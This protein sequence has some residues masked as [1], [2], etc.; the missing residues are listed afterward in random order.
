MPEAVSLG[1]VYTAAELDLKVFNKNW[2]SLIGKLG[3][4]GKQ[5]DRIVFSPKQLLAGTDAAEAGVVGLT[6]AVTGT[7]KQVEALNALKFNPGGILR[8]ADTVIHALDS[9]TVT[10]KDAAWQVLSLS[11]KS[12][13]AGDSLKG[14]A[15]A[16]TTAEGKVGALGTATGAAATTT[17]DMGA[18]G[19]AAG[20]E[21]SV[22]ADGAGVAK[23][24]VSGLGR[25]AGTALPKL[26]ALST[27]KFD[28]AGVVAGADEATA[29]ISRT[30][31][32]A[33]TART[34]LG[35]PVVFG[36]GVGGGGARGG[37][38]AA[39]G[40]AAGRSLGGGAANVAA[41]A[42]VIAGLDLKNYL[43]FSDTVQN[44]VGNSTIKPE[45]VAGMRDQALAQMRRGASTHGGNAGEEA[46]QGYKHILNFGYRGKEA[47][48]ISDFGDKFGIATHTNV[49]ETDD[50]LAGVMNAYKHMPAKSV[51][52]VGNVLHYA[53]AGS[54]MDV[55]DLEKNSTRTIGIA[56]S[57][58][59][60]EGLPDV[61]AA[62]SALVQ[63]RINPSRADTQISG[64]LG[65]IASPSPKALKEA[66]KLGLKNFNAEGLRRVQLTG[67]VNE[68]RGK[69][70]GLP[71]N[72]Q[73]RALQSLFNNKQGGTGATFLTGAAH[74]SM[75]TALNDPHTGTKAAFVGKADAI[76]PLYNQAA[77]NPAQKLRA[78]SGELKADSIELGEKFVPLLTSAVPVLK[79]FADAAQRLVGA[80]T[81]LPQP[82]QEAIIG[83]GLFK[84]A[85]VALGNPLLGLG[86]GIGSLVAKL[87]G[88][89]EGGA[90]LAG[91]GA[92][93]APIA[94]VAV[95]VVAFAV[96]WKTNFA[97]IRQAF[98]PFLADVQ[99]TFGGMGK[100]IRDFVKIILPDLKKFGAEV[101][102][103]FRV[104]FVQMADTIKVTFDVIKAVA[105]FSLAII[106]GIIRTVLAVL[107][108]N[109]K[110]AWAGIK[111]IFDG[112]WA[113]ILEL[114]KTLV[115]GFVRWIVNLGTSIKTGWLAAM[116]GLKTTFANSGRDILKAFADGLKN[117][118][119]SVGAGIKAAASS[120]ASLIPSSVRSV[121]QI[122]SPSR[123]MHE[124]GRH[125]A[126]G[127]ADG[128]TA[129]KS[130][131]TASMR[132]V[133]DAALKES[134]HAK[135]RL[136]I[137]HEA[138]SLRA[139]GMSASDVADFRQSAKAQLPS[140][141]ETGR[142]P[143]DTGRGSMAGTGEAIAEAAFQ[144]YSKGLSRAYQGLCEGL[145]HDTYKSVTG[146]YEKYMAG[147]KDNTALK[148][149]HRF[150]HAG[151]AER[152][153]PGMSLAPGSLLYSETLGHGKGHVQTAGPRGE[154]L[155]QYGKNHFAESDFGWFV[156][157][158]GAAKDARTANSAERKQEAQRQTE[159]RAQAQAAKRQKLEQETR[160]R[161]GAALEQL[162]SAETPAETSAGQKR[163][164]AWTEFKKNSAGLGLNAMGPYTLPQQQGQQQAT[165]LLNARL[166]HI[167]QEL[168]AKRS[169]GN[170]A[171]QSGID[172][173]TGQAQGQKHPFGYQRDQA[174]IEARHGL[175]SG[176]DVVLV[177]ERLRLRLSAIG[178]QEADDANAQEDRKQQYQLSANQI[179]LAQYQ[180]YLKGR[181]GDYSQY[182][183]EWV[184]ISQSINDIDMQLWK[185]REDALKQ[186]FDAGLIDLKDYIAGMKALEATLPATAA[187]D[188][189]AG[190]DET[191]ARAEGKDKKQDGRE[192]VGGD[193][194][195]K[196]MAGSAA[197][198][199]SRI[200]TALLHPKDKKSIFKSMWADLMG[201]LEGGAKSGL[202]GILKNLMTGGLKSGTSG[203]FLGSLFGGLFGGRK[204]AT[205]AISAPAASG[206]G[207]SYTSDASNG[208]VM[209]SLLP[210]LSGLPLGNLLNTGLAGGPQG[211][212]G[213]VGGL[214]GIGGLQGLTGILSG[215][216]S[217]GGPLGGLGSLLPM[218]GG[219]GGLTGLLGHGGLATLG[220]ILPWVG[221]GLLLNKVLGNP[222]GKAFKGIKKLF[223]FSQGT[224]SV[225][226]HGSGDTVPAMLTP[227]E[228]VLPK[229]GAERVRD[230][231]KGAAGAG[232]SP[233][234]RQP[235]GSSPINVHLTHN[236]DNHG[237]GDVA[238]MHES[239]AMQIKQQLPVVTP[240]T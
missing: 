210:G 40:F 1:T 152:Y 234:F 128:I 156:P 107:T 142:T 115:P 81:R 52:R 134:N 93:A 215:S 70:L 17:R 77:A 193:G 50:V 84:L 200:L 36:A 121:L 63:H 49:E 28:P 106:G 67:V 208:M 37:G 173:L 202:A 33:R 24:A 219:K 163:T 44:V 178:K 117:G 69:I 25:A 27:A 157:P 21:L 160:E 220:H 204:S 29:A 130:G 126:Q 129:G 143:I 239:W 10:A 45:D 205:G 222:L 66:D 197:D 191:I 209:S 80:I 73:A 203:G 145:A 224:W 211:I 139:G 135:A 118:I 13:E 175:D 144:K 14:M 123:V 35:R 104:A 15:R 233:A 151:L 18:A 83:L 230:A 171:V 189:K 167:Q 7:I 46:A 23:T 147:G 194:F 218:L 119:G 190:V 96:A 180:Q 164:A 9:V 231:F 61:L 55:K 192:M 149:L 223:H 240:G 214:Q 5:W 158:P 86:E 74:D 57:R 122:H 65:Q 166:D 8:G 235:G 182:S 95:A 132:A 47:A 188:V 228:M 78:L 59:G 48:T 2:D 232:A 196:D 97:G 226:G 4:L 75:Q 94:L 42:T 6:K 71:E 238:K 127:L 236:G 141:R 213:P 116:T 103:I 216:P 162:K 41:G 146:A 124:I 3:D 98:A 212:N 150:Q 125:T 113:A 58:M 12:L 100:S 161:M 185:Q 229:S 187:P 53:A 221:G 30:T 183:S 181:L 56:A 176:A 109:W 131:V 39:A 177:A 76:T 201:S 138:R 159:S 91:L 31:A 105:K 101:T 88:V 68:V 179:S 227:G 110:G 120:L 217:Q 38:R 137:D 155:D 89:E 174:Q 19:T 153:T 172:E 225:P 108:G 34:V 92:A 32:A 26:D 112:T 169:A 22:L 148:T 20:A 114:A 133:V 207:A 111:S 11:A 82:V 186:K 198:N 102:P 79:M 62:Y 90:A 168:D 54:N 136:L 154:R 165:A 16:A 140:G 99:Q 184:Q 87:A 64:M 206:P 51:G 195:W 199:G 43:E 170:D 237:A 85:T 60:P 72:D